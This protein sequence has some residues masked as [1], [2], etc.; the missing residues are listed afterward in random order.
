MGVEA[1]R[2]YNK[3][4][5]IIY[6]LL[7]VIGFIALLAVTSLA[8]GGMLLGLVMINMADNFLHLVIGL[9]LAY[10]GFGIQSTNQRL[11]QA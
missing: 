6:L 8:P 4:G 5:G 11:Q 2:L 3:I 9:V 7:A 1:S 10:V